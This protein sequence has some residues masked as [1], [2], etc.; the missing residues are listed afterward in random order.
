MK[1]ADGGVVEK[2]K[3]I[4]V[5]LAAEALKEQLNRKRLLAF[6]YMKFLNRMTPEQLMQCGH[7]GKT[8]AEAVQAHLVKT[9]NEIESAIVAHERKHLGRE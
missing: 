3:L 5:A 8:N 9:L 7:R 2:R 6:E 1:A 4:E